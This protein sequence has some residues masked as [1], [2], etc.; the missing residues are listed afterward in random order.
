MTAR[1]AITTPSACRAA[2]DAAPRE[3][4]GMRMAA[5]DK[6]L[7]ANIEYGYGLGW[8]FT[9]LTGKRPTLK[10]WPTLPRETLAEALAWAAQGNVG[11]R[12]GAVSGVVVIDADPGAD[13]APLDLPATIT[14]RTGRDGQHLYYRYTR[15]VGNST[16][17]LGPHIDVRG[18]G[19]QVVYPGSVHPETGRRY[20]WAKG[21][22]PWEIAVA[23]LPAHILERLNDH[24]VAAAAHVGP[25]P[26]RAARAE[27]YAQAALEGELGALR[28]APKASATR[29]STRPHSASARWWAAGT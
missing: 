3:P 27:R 8:S 11:L 19:G 29:R 23:E 24:D 12:T 26:P 15:P 7:A 21:L 17:K 5:G 25:T 28:A 6:L 22:A 9:P 18:D 20:E 16:G 14:A 13:L 4:S 10:S 2:S 1:L